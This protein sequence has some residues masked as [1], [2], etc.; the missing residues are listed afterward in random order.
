MDYFKVHNLRQWTHRFYMAYHFP[1]YIFKQLGLISD[2]AFR[3]PW[4]AHLG[5]YLRG[6]SVEEAY[7]IWDWVA[8]YQVSQNWRADTCQILQRASRAR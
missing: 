6:Y 7:Q 3:K 2:Q 5:W 8:E 1:L 4:P